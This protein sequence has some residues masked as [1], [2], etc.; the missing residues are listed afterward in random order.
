MERVAIAIDGQKATAHFGHCEG[1]VLVDV[2]NGAIADKRFIPNPGHKPGF[3]PIFLGDQGVSTVV[4]GGMGAMAV[5]LF[6]ERGI[7]VIIGA[8]GTVEEVMDKYLAKELISTGSACEHH[9]HE[10]ECGEHDSH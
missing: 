8:G 9:D 4:S 3:L 7:E 2:E 6:N 10:D 5:N 1:F